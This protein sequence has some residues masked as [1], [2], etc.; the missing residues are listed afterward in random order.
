MW[1]IL[2]T[3]ILVQI[4]I[5]RGPRRRQQR[6]YYSAHRTQRPCAMDSP[7]SSGDSAPVQNQNPGASAPTDTSKLPL[8]R[9]GF[10]SSQPALMKAKPTT[11][12]LGATENVFEYA[13]KER[14]GTIDQ[15][16]IFYL[17]RISLY[18]EMRMTD[19]D[20]YT[21][22]ARELKTEHNETVMDDPQ[23]T[24][25]KRWQHEPWAKKKQA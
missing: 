17:A 6:G 9:D 21:Q 18:N 22:L 16:G 23:K 5:P 25:R 15:S 13:E 4:P 24:K 11:M 10:D 8:D 2:L 14:N 3:I 1:G 20:I 7:T 12:P 19:H